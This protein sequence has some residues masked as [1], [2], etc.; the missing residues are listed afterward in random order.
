[1]VVL[2]GAACGPGPGSQVSGEALFRHHCASCHG[3]EGLGD[4]PLGSELRTPPADLT[5]LARIAGGKF[6]TAAVK[7]A[8]DGRRAVQAHGPRDM[9]VWGV[10]FGTQ[11]VGE[12]FY[13]QRSDRELDALVE[14]VRSLQAE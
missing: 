12:P 3:P 5:Q 4:G 14:Y 8:I 11:H 13:V 1:M 10:V 7:E 9:P 2:F 6:D